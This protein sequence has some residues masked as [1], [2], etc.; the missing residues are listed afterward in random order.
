MYMPFISV[1]PAFACS[2]VRVFISIPL[3]GS[4]CR[5]VVVVER[6][7]DMLDIEHL[8][9]EIEDVAK[10]ELRELTK[11]VSRSCSPIC[12]NGTISQPSALAVARQ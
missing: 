1:L 2:K 11:E 10:A 9:D 4:G 5:Q 3:D 6:R 8:A 12:S 7:F